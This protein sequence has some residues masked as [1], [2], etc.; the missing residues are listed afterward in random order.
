MRNKKFQRIVVGI[1]IVLLGIP[2]LDRSKDLEDLDK[3]LGTYNLQRT[4]MDNR[5]WP[6]EC[7]LKKTFFKSNGNYH[8]FKYSTID[9]DSNSTLWKWLPDTFVLSGT[10]QYFNGNSLVRERD[11]A[12]VGAIGQ[13]Q[14]F[15]FSYPRNRSV[16]DFSM[17]PIVKTEEYSSQSGPVICIYK[18]FAKEK[19]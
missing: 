1:V 9:K 10:L 11:H 5:K 3:Y 16:I 17:F 2:F 12:F 15:Y 6:P 13:I 8:F 19:E 4:V 18:F 14:N 7:D